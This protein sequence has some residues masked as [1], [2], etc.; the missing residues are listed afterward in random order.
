MLRRVAAAVHVDQP[1]EQRATVV[2]EMHIGGGSLRKP[3]EPRRNLDGASLR[4]GPPHYAVF[5]LRSGM[6]CQVPRRPRDSQCANDL[7]RLVDADPRFARRYTR[8]D[9][10]A[11]DA[12]NAPE[13]RVVVASTVEHH[14]AR[15]IEL[16]HQRQHLDGMAKGRSVRRF[17]QQPPDHDARMV[18]IAADQLRDV[19]IETLRSSAASRQSERRHR[20]PRTRAARFHRTGPTGPGCAAPDE[21][22]HVEAHHLHVQQIAPQQIRIARE[23]QPD[24]I[25]VTR[26]RAA[27]V[28]PATVESEIAVGETKVPE[29]A[30]DRLLIPY[31][32]RVG[33][34]A[35]RHAIQ[36]RISQIP[37]VRIIQLQLALDDREAPGANVRACC[38]CPQCLAA[39]G[40]RNA[41]RQSSRGRL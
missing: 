9:V 16:A 4:S 2:Q 1:V 12:A 27:Q 21:A 3:D 41:E 35:C 30:L 38:D 36:I 17:V 24:G 19:L 13:T 37:E 31:A 6:K 22:D 20:I 34:D 15:V 11:R 33:L 29:S 40:R 18:A 14:H 7:F 25:V 10:E 23:L 8:P 28:Q 32:R 39:G 26:V 5:T